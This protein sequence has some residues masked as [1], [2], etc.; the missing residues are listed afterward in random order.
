[1]NSTTSMVMNIISISKEPF[2]WKWIGTK[3]I[4]THFEIEVVCFVSTLAHHLRTALP[5]RCP[6]LLFSI[7]WFFVEENYLRNHFMKNYS[8]AIFP[9]WKLLRK[10]CILFVFISWRIILLL[11]PSW[12]L[13]RK[14]CILFVFSITFRWYDDSHNNPTTTD[15]QNYPSSVTLIIIPPQSHYHTSVTLSH[16]RPVF[17]ESL[18][19]VIELKNVNLGAMKLFLQLLHGDETCG[20]ALEQVGWVGIVSNH[21]PVFSSSD[22]CWPITSQYSRH[23]TTDDQWQA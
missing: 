1:M 8:F 18:A 5:A 6:F 4:E 12:K 3:T 23:V 21:K 10:E 15:K 2:S 9:S 14:E 16:L 19:K 13:L 17:R 7:K 22:Y 20:N 11:Y